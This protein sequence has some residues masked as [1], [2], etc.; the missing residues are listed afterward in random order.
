MA[1]DLIL[2]TK[3]I[4]PCKNSR[5]LHSCYIKWPF[6]Y[7]IR[8]ISLH[9]ENSISKAYLCN[10]GDIASLFLSRLACCILNLA[11][12]HSITLIQAYTHTLLNVETDYLSQEWL[13]PE[14]HLL[15]CIAHAEFHLWGQLEVESTGFIMYKSVSV[16]LHLGKLINLWDP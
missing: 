8:W 12:K 7:P 3:C 15:P 11:D 16:L 1:P 14:W 4:L 2:C 6:S 9:L 5:L 10:Q 13:V